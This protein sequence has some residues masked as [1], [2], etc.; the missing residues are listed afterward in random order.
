MNVTHNPSIVTP[1][2]TIRWT[3]DNHRKKGRPNETWRM[4]VEKGMRET[5]LEIPGTMCN[6]SLESTSGALMHN[7][8][9]EDYVRNMVQYVQS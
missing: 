3:P 4:T 9:E 1:R 6:N 8:H 2:D 7:Q 5:D